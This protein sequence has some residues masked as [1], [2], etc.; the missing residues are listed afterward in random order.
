MVW[1]I[2]EESVTWINNVS[3]AEMALQNAK[4]DLISGSKVTIYRTMLKSRNRSFDQ[5]DYPAISLVM[6]SVVEQKHGPSF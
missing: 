6:D 4:D 1:L 3:H 2:S 5:N